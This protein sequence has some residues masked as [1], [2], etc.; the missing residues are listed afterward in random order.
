MFESVQSARSERDRVGDE[1]D[2]I[3]IIILITSFSRK[4]F[5]NKFDFNPPLCEPD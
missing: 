3:E 4:M 5:K 2:N 1:R